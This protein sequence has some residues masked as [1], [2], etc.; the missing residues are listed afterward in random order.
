MP[1]HWPFSDIDPINLFAEQ[2]C[3]SGSDGNVSTISSYWA[4]RTSA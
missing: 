1:N 4:K 3:Q 2:F